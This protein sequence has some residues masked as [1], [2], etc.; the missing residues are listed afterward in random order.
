MIKLKGL[1]FIIVMVVTLLAIGILT[2]PEQADRQMMLREGTKQI[3]EA[4]AS[5][6]PESYLG[7]SK[8]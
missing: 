3:M 5:M 8:A 7:N 4:L 1:A 2:T 6:L